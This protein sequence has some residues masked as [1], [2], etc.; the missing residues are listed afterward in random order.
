MKRKTYLPLAIS[1]AFL[2]SIVVTVARADYIGPNRTIETTQWRRREC[3]YRAVYD[4]PGAGFYSCTLRLYQTPGSS[5]AAAGSTATYFNPTSCAD[6]TFSCTDA[7]IDCDISFQGTSLDS[8]SPGSTGCRETTS[9]TTLDPATV[10]GNF[11]CAIEGDHGW[12]L[13]GAAIAFNAAEP[14]TPYEIEYIEGFSGV[15][16]DPPDNPNVSCTWSNGD[17][18]QQSYT[19]WAHSTYGDTSNQGTANWRL[20]SNPPIPGIRVSGG[21][22]G[23]GDWYRGGPLVVAGGGSDVSPGSGVASSEVSVGGAPYESSVTIA[24]EGWYAVDILTTDQAGHTASSSTGV[25]VDNTAP[26]L[27]M[28]TS[29]TVGLGGWYVSSTVTST[30]SGTDALSGIGS[31][32]HQVDG[33]AWQSGAS[34]NV[35]GEGTHNVNWQVTDL[36]G[37]TATL[38]QT[39]NIDSLGPASVFTSPP[40]GST[41]TTNGALNM[42]GSSADA[43]S[44]L[45]GAE[46]SL[47]GGTTWSNLVL[48]GGSWHY[49][50]D[51]RTVP[52]GTYTVL[53]R[54][55]DNAGNLETTAQ[56][57][58][59]VDNEGP[60]VDITEQ[61]MIWE[62]ASLRVQDSGIGIRNAALVIDGG[63]YGERRYFWT[64]GNIPGRFTWDRHFGDLIAPPGEYQA[65]LTAWDGL[66]NSGSDTGVVIIPE[67]PTATPTLAPTAIPAA[68]NRPSKRALKS[69]PMQVAMAPVAPDTKNV[70]PQATET[71][72]QSAPIIW[73][74]LLVIVGLAGIFGAV[75][76][77]D[78]RP[79]VW[80]R[81]AEIRNQ[82]FLAEEARKKK[83]VI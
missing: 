51:T 66:G 38:S 24:T 16:C 14:I 65:I 33:G 67:P 17:E 23:S 63:R 25:G 36:A 54:A 28:D 64:S 52:N 56:I 78:P 8:C 27:H 79:Q 58:V 47:N 45:R 57:M 12:C 21:I 77:F 15:F 40:D 69:T 22:A 73:W 70:A 46:I 43:T 68:T 30:E 41:V 34:A 11:T 35:I 10:R 4:P 26:V 31:R 18:G 2:I 39:I 48:I 81:L 62:T 55:A 72:A 53:V 76:F 50:W 1:A 13:A 19:F 71:P 74:P 32:Q 42:H 6:W 80:R 49:S 9:T 20:D 5:C 75:G 82:A 60:R 44:G 3:R 59:I 61:W 83:E 37:N 29:G 7:G